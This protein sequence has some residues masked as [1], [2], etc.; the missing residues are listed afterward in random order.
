M[1]AK[2]L[3]KI[4]LERTLATCDPM[5]AVMVLLSH[6]AGLRV[7]S[8]K[9]RLTPNERSLFN[10]LRWMCRR[11]IQQE[12]SLLEADLKEAKS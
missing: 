2:T 5:Q 10:T 4:E 6:R 1:R 12:L 3:S 9:S 8:G 7:H 11:V